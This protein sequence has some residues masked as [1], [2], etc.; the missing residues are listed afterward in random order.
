MVASASRSLAV[1]PPCLA[2][3]IASA[4]ARTCLF[5]TSNIHR[6]WLW[7]RVKL[8]SASARA[9][10]VCLPTGIGGP[11]L[12][13]GIVPGSINPYAAVTSSVGLTH[14]NRRDFGDLGSEPPHFPLQDWPSL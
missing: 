13:L 7:R 5:P 6:A 3:L 9:E 8:N 2:F 1:T 10:R 4:T 14:C 12:P 11:Y